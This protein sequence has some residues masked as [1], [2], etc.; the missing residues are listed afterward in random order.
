[1]NKS[2]QITLAAL[3]L[4]LALIL[5]FVT[6]QIPSIG[7]LLTPMHF[8]IIIAAIFLGPIYGFGLGLAAPVLRTLLFGMPPLPMALSMS[9][10]LAVYGLVMGLMMNVVKESKMSYILKVLCSLIVAMVLGRI[11]F[12]IAAMVFLG[13]ND[14][15]ATFIG[16]F[17]GSFVGIILQLILIPLIAVRIKKS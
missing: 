16:T 6:V 1:M 11:A 10:E 14:F 12:A 8:P 15:I 5:P 9:V 2:R 4:A 17:T 7:Q 3:F 13:F